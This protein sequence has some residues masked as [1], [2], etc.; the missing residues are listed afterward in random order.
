MIGFYNASVIATYLSLASALFGMYFAYN[1]QIP[2]A[3]L[4]LMF[5]GF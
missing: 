1:V 2:Q 4:C 3:M 5:S